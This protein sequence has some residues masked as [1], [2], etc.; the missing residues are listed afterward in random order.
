[1]SFI[2]MIITSRHHP[3]FAGIAAWLEAAQKTINDRGGIFDPEMG[4]RVDKVT[5]NESEMQVFHR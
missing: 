3:D 2:L 5:K 1:M 4:I